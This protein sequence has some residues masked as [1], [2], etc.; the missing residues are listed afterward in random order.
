MNNIDKVIGNPLVTPM[1]G[2]TKKE[3]DDIVGSIGTG[4]GG[5]SIEIDDAMS[6]TSE[7]AVKN[8]I[9]KQ[10][11]DGVFS[12]YVGEVSAAFDELRTYAEG[13]ISGGAE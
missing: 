9:I 2:Y 7:N 6:D 4:G 8:K 3:V 12:E 5:V 11:V 10:Y 1:N 13:L